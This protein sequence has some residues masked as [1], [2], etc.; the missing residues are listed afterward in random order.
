MRAV[1]FL[2]AA[3]IAAPAYA[4]NSQYQLRG[5]SA[6]TDV[7]VGQAQDV[8][9]TSVAG[10]NA[11]TAV[12]A[13]QDLAY[14]NSQHMDGATR[15][16]TDATV[17]SAD[18]V[19]AVAAAAVANGAT[20]TSEN[21][22]LDITSEQLAHNDAS[23]SVQFRGG[24]AGHASTSASAAGN[25]AAGAIENGQMRAIATQESTGAVSATIEADHDVVNGAGVSAAVASANNASIAGST[26]T[27]LTDTTQN[28][29]GSARAQTDFYVGL[30][31]DVS[32]N[33]A[34]NANALTIANEWGYVNARARQ[35][36]DADV[37]ANSYVT[38][39]GDFLGF[40]SAGAYGVGNAVTVSN[41][42]SDTVLDVV[43]ANAGGVSANAALIGEGGEMALASAAA[44][45]NSISAGLCNHC[46]VNRP[47]LRASSDQVN[48]GDVAARASVNA[49]RARTVGATATAI[50]NAAT[51]QSVPPNS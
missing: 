45:G 36:S 1:L 6:E 43:Q 5:V 38:L 48:D 42:G 37:E 44:Y 9:A 25:V 19:V 46:D 40:A 18:N 34:A 27:V 8:G 17:W 7:T 23:A 35:S 14:S 10:G 13:D 26:A 32:G 4:Q 49:P 33:A 15:A 47:E 28:A 41:I 3:L 39:G 50:G 21:G 51:Y 2:S 24:D 11:V 30:G 16:S 12:S 20:A 29:S 22:D 31:N